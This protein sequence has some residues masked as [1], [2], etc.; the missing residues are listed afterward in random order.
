M[1]RNVEFDYD[2]AIDKATK[3]FRITGY[4]NTSL[5]D[6]LKAMKIGEGSFYN[7]LKSKKHLYLECLKHYRA[8]VGQRREDAMFSAPSAKE[9]VRAF[10]KVIFDEMDDPKTGRACLMANSMC[11]E[12]LEETELRQ[13]LVSEM[14]GFWGRFVELL[15][16]SQEAGDLPRHLEPAVVAQIIGTYLQGLRRVALVSYDRNRFERQ[17]D[18][19]LTELGL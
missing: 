16:T 7:A 4:S 14:A 1:G 19:F 18:V 13:Y 11:R 5:R 9:G 12:V 6:L 2:K 10:F 8:T 3:L 15:K 17:T